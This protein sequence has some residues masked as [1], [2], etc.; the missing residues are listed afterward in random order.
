MGEKKRK[1]KELFT[2]E[3]SKVVPYGVKDGNPG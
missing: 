3:I 2:G 1:D